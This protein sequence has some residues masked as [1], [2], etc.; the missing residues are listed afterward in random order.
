MK[1]CRPEIVEVTVYPW[2]D[3]TVVYVLLVAVAC[4]YVGFWNSE[5]NPSALQKSA[6]Y[7]AAIVWPVA[8]LVFGCVALA[9]LAYRAPIAIT[10]LWRTLRGDALAEAEAVS[11]ESDR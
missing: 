6:R 10:Q 8:A 1:S 5:T 9:A 3:M 7:G 2:N 4:L 11:K